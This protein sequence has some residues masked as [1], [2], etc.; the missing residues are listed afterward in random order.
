MMT[1]KARRSASRFCGRRGLAEVTDMKR[2]ANRKER[3][4][5]RRVLRQG[6][7]PAGR[8]TRPVTEWDVD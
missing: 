6:E 8:L 4:A 3:R 5:Q 7:E 2:K 1:Q